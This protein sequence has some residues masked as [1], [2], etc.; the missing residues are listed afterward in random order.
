MT[1][2]TVLENSTQI[3]QSDE[4]EIEKNEISAF[5]DKP[6]GLVTK[7][8]LHIKTKASELIPLALNNTQKSIARIILKQ[9]ESHKPIRMWV[10]KARQEGVSTLIEAIIY[11]FTSQRENVNS[12][13]MADE[14][15]HAN[16]LFDM[17]KLYQE[18]LEKQYAHLAPKLKK[19]NEKK[20]EFEG[21]HSQ[22][23]IATAENLEAAK[24][25][26]FQIVHLSEVAYFRDL[27]TVMSDLNQTVPDLPNTMIIGETTANGMELFY[28]EWLRA[29]QGKTDWLPVF[30]PWFAL[31]EYSMPIQGELYPIDGIIFDADNTQQD[32]LKEEKEITEECDLTQEQVNWR[33][34]SI[35]NKCNGEI[36]IFNR[37]YPYCVS[38]E[39]YISSEESGIV[40]IKDVVCNKTITHLFKK[41]IKETAK[42]TTSLGY[43]L[44]ITPDHIV[45]TTKGDKPVSELTNNDE[46]I[47]S[48]PIFAKKQKVINWDIMPDIVAK[49]AITEDMGRFLG[50]FMGDGSLWSTQFSF[51]CYKDEDIIN[52]IRLLIKQIS[53]KE[54]QVRETGK[55][56]GNSWEVRCTSKK[57]QELF[58]L[59]GATKRSPSDINHIMRNVCVPKCIFESSKNV[60]KEF[61]RGVFEAD[62][63]VGYTTRKVGFF[64]KYEQFIKDIQLLLLGFGITA[65]LTIKNKEMFGHTYTGRELTLRSAEATK[66]VEEIGFVSDRKNGRITKF[67]KVKTGKRGYSLEMKDKVKS[68]E[69][70]G[71][72]EVYDITYEPTH[73]FSA[74]G[75]YIHNCWQVAF[76]TS[77]KTFFNQQALSKQLKKTPRQIGD[78]FKE[79]YKY[80]LREL[81]TGRIKIYEKPQ[82][83]EQYIITIDAS[84]AI[85][86]DEGSILVLN[87]RLNRT[88]AV[89]NGQYEPELLADMASKLGYYYNDALIAPENKGYGYMVCQC[90]N[91]TYGHIYRRKKTK[92][93]VIEKTDELGFNTNLNTRPEMLGRSAETILHNS[94]E[95]VDADVINQ[96]QTFVINPKNRKPEAALGK[97]DGLVIAFSIAQQVRHEHPYMSP[98]NTSTQEIR[99]KNRIERNKP[100][101]RF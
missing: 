83:N 29:V 74:N 99:T 50:Y 97:Q 55:K 100:K 37:E 72:Q 53:G 67:K 51:A 93:G 11:A 36:A 38:G 19:S 69:L 56:Q 4:L 89:V 14:K 12:L 34:W 24:S 58:V 54:A 33:R 18:M 44:E 27:K 26:T 63:F 46:I 22:I 15:D 39:T 49:V 13:I 92:D 85:G 6:L 59:L 87:N 1:E 10:L 68:I 66:F 5:R 62:G 78:I 71:E 88:V 57:M 60:V 31:D 91:K 25:H 98:R 76:Q 95:L 32:F 94:C 81:P 84:E 45:C 75:L 79:E 86:E 16:N 28:D 80:I 43:T 77:G 73:L 61:L 48:K 8:Y 35:V 21:I 64:S 17:S 40:K 42:I 41:G 96:H 101:N 47:L 9:L 7:R 30:I 2:Q 70:I 3:S 52:D 23:I 82:P 20:L 65:K 90:L